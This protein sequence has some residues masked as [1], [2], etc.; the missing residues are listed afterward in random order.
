MVYL[1]AG[2]P[3]KHISHDALPLALEHT[4]LESMEELKVLLDQKPQSAGKRTK[5]S[6]K[7]RRGYTEKTF[8]VATTKNKRR[9]KLIK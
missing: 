9:H 6:E 1:F 7:V 4:L 5:D 3:H 8:F 2:K